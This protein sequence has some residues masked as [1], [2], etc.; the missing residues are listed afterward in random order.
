MK[1]RKAPAWKCALAVLGVSGALLVPGTALA[2]TASADSGPDVTFEVH[3]GF[4]VN[5]GG[6]TAGRSRDHFDGCDRC[7]DGG[8]D[9]GHV[10][11]WDWAPDGADPFCPPDGYRWFD[12][13]QGIAWVSEWDNHPRGLNGLKAVQIGN[14]PVQVYWIR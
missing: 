10:A 12:T 1:P 13:G 3:G 8:Y 5:F 6:G 2:S 9:Q 11:K 14:G 4:S 7:D